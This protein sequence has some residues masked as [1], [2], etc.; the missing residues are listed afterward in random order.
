MDSKLRDKLREIL[1]DLC[2]A[3]DWTYIPGSITD[4]KSFVKGVDSIAKLV[5]ESLPEKLNYDFAGGGNIDWVNEEG[6]KEGW[7]SLLHQIKAM[8]ETPQDES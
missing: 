8:W 1:E 3:A 7:N 5:V 4:E 2:L 6:K